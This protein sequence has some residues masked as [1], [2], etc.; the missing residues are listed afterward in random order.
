MPNARTMAL[1]VAALAL[2]GC[3]KQQTQEDQNFAVTN[4]IPGNADIET[5]PPDESSGTPAD[6][7][8]NGNDNAD[9]ADL[10]ASQN[11]Y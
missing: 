3:H 1:A 11:S 8:E 10:N 7:L 4:E 5:L 9:V 6:Q 2:A